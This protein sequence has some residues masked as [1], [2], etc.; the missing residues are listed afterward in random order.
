MLIVYLFGIYIYDNGRNHSSIGEENIKNVNN[1]IN[2]N[3]LQNFVKC[4]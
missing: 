2:N 3:S 1:G 4:K